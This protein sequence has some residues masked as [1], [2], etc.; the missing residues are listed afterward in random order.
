LKTIL[1][2][3]KRLA[4]ARSGRLGPGG[5]DPTLNTPSVIMRYYYYVIISVIE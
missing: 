2:L 4:F 1:G 3:R 5:G